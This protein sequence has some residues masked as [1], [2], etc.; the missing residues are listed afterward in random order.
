MINT[1][2]NKLSGFSV[3]NSFELFDGCNESEQII[4]N[5]LRENVSFDSLFIFKTRK[6]FLNFLKFTSSMLLSFPIGIF[7]RKKIRR[8]KRL[9]HIMQFKELL[10]VR[11]N[12]EKGSFAYDT[13]LFKQTP[14]QLFKNKSHLVNL[15]CLAIL[16]GDEFIDGVATTYGRKNIQHILNNNDFSYYLHHKK[17]D[18]GL[19]LYYE[20]DICDVLPLSVQEGINKK[21]G[22]TYKAFYNHL[23]FLLAEMNLHLN[24]LSFEKSEEAA[25]LI[26]KVCNRCFDTYKADINEF[27]ENHTLTDLLQYQK[28][29]DEDII[30]ILLTLRA[31]LL[32]KKQLQYQKRFSSWGSMVR[33]MQLYDDMQDVAVDCDFQMN[34]LSYFAK[35]YFKEEWSWLQKNK[36]TLQELKGL[37]LHSTIAFNMPASCILTLQYARNITHSRLCWVQRKIQNYLWRKNWLGFNN[38]LLA[39]SEGDIAEVINKKEKSI[40]LKL[41]YIKSQVLKIDQHFI[42]EQMKWSF[43]ADIALLDQE[44]KYYIFQKISRKEKYLLLS[45]YLEFPIKQKAELAKKLFNIN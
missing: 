30:Q 15:V 32:D 3:E 24:K 35:N 11:N 26:C 20:F 19:E 16:F 39:E 10:P 22:I 38:P 31:V 44:L 40:P 43:M 37:K 23:Q 12:I 5:M 14:L 7:M 36:N 9:N 27:D 18:K 8:N 6:E 21:Y 13:I 17:T 4:L 45:C 42:T 25:H 28:D 34:T 2:D 33:S 29:K 41:H 1:A